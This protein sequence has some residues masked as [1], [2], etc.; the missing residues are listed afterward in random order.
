M[1]LPLVSLLHF[2]GDQI[3]GYLLLVWLSLG[4]LSSGRGDTRSPFPLSLSSLVFPLCRLSA[5]PLLW[6]SHKPLFTK[7]GPAC[8]LQQELTFPAPAPAFPCSVHCS[9]QP[10]ML[11]LDNLFTYH[12]KATFFIFFPCL[13]GNDFQ[14]LALPVRLHSLGQVWPAHLLHIPFHSGLCRWPV[15]MPSSPADRLSCILHRHG[16][17]HCKSDAPFIFC[18]RPSDVLDSPPWE[19]LSWRRVLFRRSPELPCLRWQKRQH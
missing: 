17:S 1:F 7:T 14:S 4:T 3:L 16:L 2:L 6:L 13:L 15:G 19:H 8:L 11:S 9:P 10:L 5:V 18:R 12:P